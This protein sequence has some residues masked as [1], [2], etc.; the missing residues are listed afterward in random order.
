MIE[1]EDYRTIQCTEPIFSCELQP[2]EMWFSPLRTVV[3]LQIAI[4]P[5]F[6]FLN[7]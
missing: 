2:V 4:L 3:P 7:F 5:F 6:F 1:R